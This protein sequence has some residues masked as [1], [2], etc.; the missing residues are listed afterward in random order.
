MRNTT[1]YIIVALVAT[2]AMSS[3]S[4]K[5]DRFLNR[6]WHA[7]NTKYNVL[8]NGN[9]ALENGLNSIESSYKDNFWETLPVERLNI[10]DAFEVRTAQD[11]PDFE[12]AEEKAIKAVQTH[13]MNI[14]G[15]EKNPQIDEAYLLLG[16]SR[17]YSGRFIPALEAFNY[18]LFKYPA[19]SNIN[20]AKIWRAKT[21]LR[22]ENEATALENLN[23]LITRED[24]SKD[25]KIEASSTL[26]QL[27]INRGV[28]DSA[29][30]YLHSASELTKNN[31]LKGRLYFIQ[32]QLYNQKAEKDSAQIAFQ[33]VID[34]NRKVPRPYRINAM[35][36]Q[37]NNFDYS[38]DDLEALNERL[39][40]MQTNR[41][42]RPF[43]DRIYHI[44]ANHY[45]NLGND[46]L[47]VE[48]YNKSLRTDTQD[49]LL[50]AKNYHTIADI[51]F[52]ASA[53]SQAG[54]Y[55]DSTLIHYQKNSKPF[56]AVK[57]RLDNLQDVIMYESIAQTNDS[58]LRLTAMNDVEVEVFFQSV[59]DRLN[60]E[61][62][63]KQQAQS[64][65]LIAPKNAITTRTGQ[66]GGFYFYQPSTVAFGK[67]EFVSFWGERPLEDNWRWSN[68]SMVSTSSETTLSNSND[69]QKQD[70]LTTAFY[71]NQIPKDP[72]V[73][74]SLTKER[75]FAYYKLGLIYKN[76]FKDY[77]RSREKLE[78]LLHQTL[79]ERLVLPVQYNLYKLYGLLSD[80]VSAN[81]IKQQI[82]VNHPQS[83]YAQILQ[84]PSTVLQIDDQSAKAR[85][86]VLYKLFED[87]QYQQVIE[88][89]G[90][91]ITRFEGEEI[92]PK[93]ELLKA[94]AEG[95]LYG[96]ERY[97][98]GLNYIALNHP[99]S[100]EGKQASEILLN[101]TQRLSNNS[102]DGEDTSPSFKTVYEFRAND[103]ETIDTFM[104]SLNE[105][106]AEEDVL[107]LTVSK[108]V[109][110]INTTFV[111]VHGLKSI[112]GAKGFTEFLKINHPEILSKSLFAISAQHYTTLQIHKNLD[113]Y[114]AWFNK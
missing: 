94:S 53:Y 17:Y 29:L 9:L 88:G 39:T 76:K 42:N 1:K 45:K 11:N 111:V 113:Q 71:V 24:L 55:Y 14:K 63:E 43:L 87:S 104:T 67:S 31:A 92:V 33:N 12:R 15:K 40:S 84:N 21:N 23:K 22:L 3:C 5:K 13:G 65:S 2:A 74:D 44:V 114:I 41:E 34:L 105:A 112:N 91:E 37:I 69:Q 59:I 70:I 19:S 77:E 54:N 80:A 7:L 38:Q 81:Q 52:N 68:R 20:A 50:R 78:F 95:R 110:D 62:E 51:Y 6:N 47:A 86:E 28:L 89:C 102:F 108:D 30:L 48:Y 64:K 97:K 36:E 98:K 25:N 26:A 60:Q 100:L 83:R 107:N 73:I 79:E 96:Y 90:I 82:I 35:L 8:Y 99:N 27:Y 106:I 18:I 4:R 58:I 49:E 72:L 57:K 75:N 61:K 10:S 56:R 101:L 66:K 32:G 85:Y 16:I 93:F 46:S 109:Y 103:K